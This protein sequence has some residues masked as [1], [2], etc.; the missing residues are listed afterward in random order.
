MNNFHILN[1]SLNH[2]FIE[3]ILILKNINVYNFNNLENI[4]KYILLLCINNVYLLQKLLNNI[5]ILINLYL[6]EKHIYINKLQKIE[7]SLNDIN[8]NIINM[9]NKLSIKKINKLKIKLITNINYTNYINNLVNIKQNLDIYELKDLDQL[10]NNII[11]YSDDIKIYKKD[12]NFIDYKNI[13]IG[14]GNYYKLHCYK[15]LNKDL[16]FNLLIYVQEV[17]QVLIKIGNHNNFQYINS[18]LYKIYNIKNEKNILNSKS[19]LCNNNIKV[20][21]KKCYLEN[22]RY[23]HDYILGYKDNYHKDRQF[24]SNPIVFN[25]S[26][27]KDGSKIKENLQ[28]IEWHEAINLYQS[29]LSNILIG[30]IHSLNN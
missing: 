21:N 9:Y 17:D 13:N 12:N 19:I 27:F 26:D 23:Y 28:K 15:Y 11:L 24:S 29:S 8:T 5:Y 25:C 16:P 22:C 3:L 4:I 14:F 10:I 7:L 6:T 18:K 20:L 2:I 1:K 30:C